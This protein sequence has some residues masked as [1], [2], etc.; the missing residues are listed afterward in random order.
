MLAAAN[1]HAAAVELLLEQNADLSLT[2]NEGNTCLHFACSR[3]HENVA[4]LLLDKIH[5]SNI[6]N[7]ANSEL[8]TPLHI[9]ARYGLTPVV[10]DLITKGSSVYALDENAGTRTL[11]PTGDQISIGSPSSSVQDVKEHSGSYQSSDS[12]FY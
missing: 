4:L 11:E 10:Q 8:K 7:I 3:E 6:C 9:A 5:D 2:D 12:E 1:G